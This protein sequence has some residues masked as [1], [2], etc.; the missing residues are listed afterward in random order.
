MFKSFYSVLIIIVFIIFNTKIISV[1]GAECLSTPRASTLAEFP[2]KDPGGPAG[3]ATVHTAQTIVADRVSIAFEL[4]R[5][6]F[7]ASLTFYSIS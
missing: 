6:D 2:K 7:F 1:Q 3:H 5:A 4:T